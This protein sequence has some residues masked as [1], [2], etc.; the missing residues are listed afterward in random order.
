MP[1]LSLRNSQNKFDLIKRII[2]LFKVRTVS[3]KKIIESLRNIT[4]YTP[5]NID[6]Y[7]Q[8][9][10]HSSKGLKKTDISYNNERLEFLGDSV[11]GAIIS[12]YLFK[13]FP[14][15]DEGFLTQLR[16][17]MVNG[18][19]LHQLALKLGIDEILN[20]NLSKKDKL[21]SSALGDAFEALIGAFYID[22]GYERTRRFIIKKIIIL[23]MDMDDLLKT[24]NDF[25]SQLQVYC[26]KNKL[27][28]RYNSEEDV[29]KVNGRFFRVNVV[30][31]DHAYESFEHI[32]KRTAEQKAAQL[33]LERINHG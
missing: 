6:L 7:K 10:I 15:K 30:I 5:V 13:K 18:Q 8:A 2:P 3:E 27:K 9:F 33:A 17:K 20:T 1:P 25:K 32:S 16:S 23:H 21:K 22:H 29:S 28:L 14:N 24:D 19:H 31:N 11:L 12:E 26:Q 4:G